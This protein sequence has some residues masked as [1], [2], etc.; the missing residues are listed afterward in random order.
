MLLIFGAFS[1]NAFSQAKKRVL[2]LGNSYTAVNGLP[3]LVADVALSAGDTVIYQ[4]NAP[5]G[6]TLQGHA[7]N[8]TSQYMIRSGNWDFVVL[9]E[10]SQLPSFPIEQVSAEVFP[11]AR[12]LDSVIDAHNSC[13][14]TM[15]YMTWGRKNGDVQNCASWPPVC[16]YQGMDSLLRLRYLMMAESNN[17]LVSPVGAVWRYIRQHY[18]NINLYNSDN[19]H[20]SA[21]GSYAAACSFYSAIFRKDPTAISFNYSLNPA[22]A[23]NIRA[24]A[25]AVVYDSLLAWNIGRYDARADFAFSPQGNRLV[26]FTNR[27]THT[28][29]HIWYFGDGDSSLEQNPLH[30]YPQGGIYQA[31]LHTKNCYSANSITKQV[32]ACPQG[33]PACDTI[34]LFA[35][36]P[37]PVHDQLTIT[38]PGKGRVYVINAM[39]QVLQSFLPLFAEKLTL[40]VSGW[41]AGMYIIVYD[42]DGTLQK[43]RVIK[44]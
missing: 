38:V 37:N 8:N 34:R 43:K 20:P 31:S 10:Q 40:N 33:Y 21:A 39:G 32:E 13:A 44:R 3:R 36:Y 9:Q 23:A 7:F 11:F 17:A 35:V 27:S 15:F 42:L 26:Q 4:G 2:F 28:D 6:Y 41:P 5:G 24:A 12:Y 22:D 25:R 14:Q 29:N 30:L 1:L 19:S 16:T 18:P